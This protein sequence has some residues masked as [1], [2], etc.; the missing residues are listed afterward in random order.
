MEY[1]AGGRWAQMRCLF[2][3]YFVGFGFIVQA[4]S[5]YCQDVFGPRDVVSCGLAK[6]TGADGSVLAE[7]GRFA[8][9]DRAVR[10]RKGAVL[11][12]SPGGGMGIAERGCGAPNAV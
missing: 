2:R 7:K 12:F 4:W 8:A 10:G 11:T 1:S 6:R 3:M 9:G 5:V